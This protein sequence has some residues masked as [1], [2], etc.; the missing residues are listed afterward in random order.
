ML[1]NT[2]VD[3]PGNG[4]AAGLA[5]LSRGAAI[6]HLDTDLLTLNSNTQI[7]TYIDSWDWIDGL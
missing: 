3:E 1:V 7:Y 6:L 5:E 4:L 2:E